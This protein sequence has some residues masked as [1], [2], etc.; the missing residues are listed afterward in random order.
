VITTGIRRREHLKL[1]RDVSQALAQSADLEALFAVLHSSVRAALAADT[2]LLGLYDGVSRTIHVVRQG[3]FNAALPGGTFPL[4]HGLTSDVIRTGHS[5]LIRHWSREGPPVQVQYLTQTPGLPESALTVPLL[6]GDEVLGV[7]AAHKYEPDAFD[8]DDL[9]VLEAIAAPSAISLHA[10]RTSQQLNGQLRERVSELEAVLGTMADA[11]L[12]LDSEHRVVSINRAAR[13]LLCADQAGVVLGQ[14][15]DQQVWGQWPLG[16]REIAVALDPMLA[17]LDRGEV[18]REIEVRLKR[19]GRRILSFNGAPLMD[20][21]DSVRGSA[22]IVRDVTRPHEIEE[23]KDEMLSVA[24]HDLKT[25]VTVIRSDAQFLRREIA[26]DTLTMTQIDEGLGAIVRQ[27]ERL[28]RL[29]SL[30]LDVSRIESGRFEIYRSFTD[31][32][33]LA[34]STIAEV[35]ATTDRHVIQLHAASPTTG[36]WDE[37][38]L[39]QVLQNLLTNAVKYSPTSE[40]IDVSIEADKTWVTVSVTDQGL[41]LAPEEAQHVFERFFRARKTRGLEGSG[42]GLHICKSIVR[43]HGGRI[44]VESGGPGLG[45]SFH[46]AIPRRLHS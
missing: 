40:R 36:Y 44:W 28:S 1:L 17:A 43:A 46:F 25:P 26:R 33:A 32:C 31:L 16:A 2:L 27:T 35:Q 30:L 4:G 38:R 7:I 34:S 3:E 11:V 14:P 13:E 45:S 15:L 5:R 42:L 41:G 20:A 22:L 8:E 18:P 24:S 9:L 23:L 21:H 29:L 10:L 37:R 19:R 39:Q 6:F 12:L